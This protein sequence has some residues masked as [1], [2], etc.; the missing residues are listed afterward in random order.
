MKVFATVKAIVMI[1]MFVLSIN[2]GT[3]FTQVTQEQ[4]A[5]IDNHGHAW[6]CNA[7]TGQYICYQ[8]PYC[9]YDDGEGI[10]GYIPHGAMLWENFA[11]YD[12]RNMMPVSL[13]L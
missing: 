12:C 13:W 5:D 11:G 8:T 7:S 4:S 2:P 10:S 3:G 6:R 9:F 1:F